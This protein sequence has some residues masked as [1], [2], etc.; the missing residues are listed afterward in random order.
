MVSQPEAANLSRGA[1]ASAAATPVLDHLGRGGNFACAS[2]DE[3]CAAGG[4]VTQSLMQ[5]CQVGSE[6]GEAAWMAER[7]RAEFEVE[8]GVEVEAAVAEKLES[9]FES[10][11]ESRLTRRWQRAP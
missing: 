9:K 2:E 6:A 1:F 10:K 4:R 3:R 7:W 5:A 11:L 8:V